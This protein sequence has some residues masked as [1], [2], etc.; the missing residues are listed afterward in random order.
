LNE[1]AV[2]FDTNKS[3]YYC[4]ANLD[5]LVPVLQNILILISLFLDIQI[6][7]ADYNLKLSEERAASVRNYLVSKLFQ[8]GLR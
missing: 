4:K 8:E 2:R 1:N 6:P 3:N 7:P 5:K